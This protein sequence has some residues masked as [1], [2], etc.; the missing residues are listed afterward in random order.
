MATPVA[1]GSTFLGSSSAT[2]YTV[3]EGE[4]LLLKQVILCNQDVTERTVDLHSVPSAGSASAA[5]AILSQATLGVGTS[6][7]E[8]NMVLRSGETL[9]GLASEPGVVSFFGS[10]ILLS[11]DSLPEPLVFYRGQLGAGTT[12]LYESTGTTIVKGISICNA[13]DSTRTFG[14]RI[15]P[16]GEVL[17]SQ[18][19]I[20]HDR[21]VPAR[22]TV[23]MNLSSVLDVGDT[24]HAVADAGSALTVIAS[25]VAA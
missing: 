22:S 25:G 6:A 8:M 21:A 3:P 9:R 14:L 12:E 7:L 2:L 24:L 17:G 11:E 4:H 19:A 23:F 10:G 18:H 20:W 16:D 1:L 15:V 13:S 5:N